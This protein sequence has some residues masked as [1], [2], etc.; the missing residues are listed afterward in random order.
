MYVMIVCTCMYVCA[1]KH[2][3]MHVCVHLHTRV[4]MR[5][6]VCAF[7]HV[8]TCA[9]VCVH[10]HMHVHMHL[11][12][13]PHHVCLHMHHGCIC[14]CLCVHSPHCFSHSLPTLLLWQERVYTSLSLQY[15]GKLTFSPRWSNRLYSLDFFGEGGEGKV[16]L[17]PCVFV[18]HSMCMHMWQL[19][20]QIEY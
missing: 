4:H 13:Y 1:L 11:H 20:I 18:M 7:T 19:W 16:Y 6:R 10:L 5:K 12:S 17:Y 9:N 3:C 14:V 15:S 2:T 8:C